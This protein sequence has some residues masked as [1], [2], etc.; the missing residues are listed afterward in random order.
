MLPF[1]SKVQCALT[2]GYMQYINA[3]LSF[4]RKRS[5]NISCASRLSLPPLIKYNKTQ[6]WRCYSCFV[7]HY[8]SQSTGKYQSNWIYFTIFSQ[9]IKHRIGCGK[10]NSVLRPQIKCVCTR[11]DQRLSVHIINGLVF[12][13]CKYG[14]NVPYNVVCRMQIPLNYIRYA[15]RV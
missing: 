12:S 5:E 4:N 2:A 14:D 1:Y 8:S 7:T 6:T 3:R 13:I 11:P 15:G 9:I 10:N